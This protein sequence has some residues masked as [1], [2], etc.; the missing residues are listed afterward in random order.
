MIRGENKRAWKDN[1]E[2]DTGSQFPDLWSER[3]ENQTNFV[4]GKEYP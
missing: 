2:A 4:E 3:T 1:F